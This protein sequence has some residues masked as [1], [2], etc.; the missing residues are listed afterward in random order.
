MYH[1]SVYLH[2]LS[3]IFWIGGMLFTAAVLVPAS[4]DRLLADRRGAF[5]K[6]VGEKFSRISWLLFLV[7]VI[8]GLANLTGRGISLEQLLD[9]GFWSSYFGSRLRIKLFLFAGV[10]AVSGIHDF[11]AGP[12]ATSLMEEG[13]DERQTRRFRRLSSWLGRINLLLGLLILYY[14]IRLTRG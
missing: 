5:F 4:R 3:A 6:L 9:A 2:I 1:V 11:Y 12:K 13:G 10:L 8:T 14:A 7:L